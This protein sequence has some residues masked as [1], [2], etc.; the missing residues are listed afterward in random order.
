MWVLQIFFS[1]GLIWMLSS[2]NVFFRDLQN[3][4]SV[5]TLML[6]LMSPIAWKAVEIPARFLPIMHVNPLY[7]IIISYQ[8]CLFNGRF[9][10]GSL[11]PVLC[12]LAAVFFCVGWWFF[13]RMKLLFADNV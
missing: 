5:V 7:Y 3:I 8:D 1:I 6:M 2:L 4:I 13:G 12:A 9:P 10:Q 11:L